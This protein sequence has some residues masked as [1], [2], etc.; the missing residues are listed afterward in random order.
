MA[1]NHSPTKPNP[2]GMDSFWLF[3]RSFEFYRPSV[4]TRDLVAGVTLAA[5]AVSTGVAASS[6]SGTCTITWRPRP[7][8][9]RRFPASRV[10]SPPA[11]GGMSCPPGTRADTAWTWSGGRST[12]SKPRINSP[13]A[14]PTADWSR[15]RKA[16]L[17]HRRYRRPRWPRITAM[18]SDRP[19]SHACGNESARRFPGAAS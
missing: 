7:R 15:R 3:V 9:R 4:L 17:R 13:S 2:R 6:V 1:K 11:S 16:P 10:R 18:R 5:I 19:R 12:C 8:W 14:H